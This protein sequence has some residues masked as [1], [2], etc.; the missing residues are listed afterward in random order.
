[1]MNNT[2]N[3]MGNLQPEMGITQPEYSCDWG[4]GDKCVFFDGT[5]ILSDAPKNVPDFLRKYSPCTLYIESSYESY[6]N[7]VY[8]STLDLAQ[9]LSS[10]ILTVSSRKTA[11]VRWPRKKSDELDAR[12]IWDI[13]HSGYHLKV[14]KK[15][16][17][18]PL[19]RLQQANSDRRAF[20]Y[21][22]NNP[23][24]VETMSYLPEYFSLEPI[25]QDVLG[26][27]GKEYAEGFVNPILQ[28][29]LDVLEAGG[30][31]PDF[32]KRVGTYGHGYPSY[33]R[34]AIYNRANGRVSTLVKRDLKAGLTDEEELKKER[35]RQVRRATRFLFGCVKSNMGNIEPATG[36]R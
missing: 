9:D 25:L 26:N 13:A 28:T 35:M 10:I 19:G 6:L 12:I 8:N 11:Q 4:H 21:T 2:K 3:N 20:G 27:K 1:M 24:W 36:N 29:A 16:D 14:P 32:D 23:S 7:D 17:L 18:K 34:A 30:T 31:R 33:Q 5:H 15:R 22:E